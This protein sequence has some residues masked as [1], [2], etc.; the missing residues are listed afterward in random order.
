MTNIDDMRV[1]MFGS[2]FEG[3]PVTIVPNAYPIRDTLFPHINQAAWFFGVKPDY[4]REAI[5]NSDYVKVIG[6]RGEIVI[7][8][9]PWLYQLNCSDMVH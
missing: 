3:D 1:A 2:L 8:M 6:H 7:L 9:S 5:L 4:L